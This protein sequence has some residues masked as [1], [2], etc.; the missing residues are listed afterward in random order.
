M[1]SS[2]FKLMSWTLGIEDEVIMRSLWYPF[3]PSS[4]NSSLTSTPHQTHPSPPH[5]LTPFTST[6]SPPHSLKS[7]VMC[8]GTLL[9]QT[10]AIV[11]MR[12]QIQ[13]QRRIASYVYSGGGSITPN[14][15]RKCSTRSHQTTD[16]YNCTST[17]PQMII[18]EWWQRIE[19]CIM[20]VEVRGVVRID[21]LVCCMW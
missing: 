1:T 13:T 20:H 6:S 3:Y 19:N 15:V 4:P 17:R 18:P 14:N 16:M 7:V 9:N 12:T 21:F 5:P 2:S 10:A 8:G 11:P